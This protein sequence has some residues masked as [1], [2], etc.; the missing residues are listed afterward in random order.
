MLV[1]NIINYNCYLAKPKTFLLVKF[2][3]Y[4]QNAYAAIINP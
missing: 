4:K 2:S 3:K 1:K